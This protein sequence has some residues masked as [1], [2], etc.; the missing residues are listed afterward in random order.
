MT[1]EELQKK[2]ELLQ[3]KLSEA[4]RENDTERIN[5][6]VDELNALWDKASVEMLKNAEAGGFYTPDKS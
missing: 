2:L 1:N 3:T 6:Y 4:N 5:K